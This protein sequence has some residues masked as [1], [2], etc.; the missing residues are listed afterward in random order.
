MEKIEGYKTH[1]FEKNPI[2]QKLHDTFIKD[3]NREGYCDMDLIVFGHPHD[4]L[5]PRD[6]LTDKEKKIVIST[7][8]WLGSPVG[9]EFLSK[10]G[11]K[12]TDS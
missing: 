7:V 6:Y 10:C 8:Q 12:L 2:E 11:F 9:Q 3:N 4:S 1:R 5:L